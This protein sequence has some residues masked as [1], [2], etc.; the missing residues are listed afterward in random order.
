MNENEALGK[1]LD[2]I[3]T[4]LQERLRA[5]KRDEKAEARRMKIEAE[6][7]LQGNLQA[8][9]KQHAQ[10]MSTKAQQLL[11]EARDE[12]KARLWAFEQEAIH[13]I[14]TG[15]CTALSEQPF[16]S[17]QFDAWLNQ[18]KARLGNATELLLEVNAA[19]LSKANC[20]KISVQKRGMLGGAI[21]TDQQ[22]GQ[23]LDG[24]WECRLSDLMPEIW[25]RWKQDVGKDYQA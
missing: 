3:E 23:Q 24:S 1:L 18:A 22:S 19:W 25:Q 20:Q 15:I 4:R 5:I 21:L 16:R 8:R 13:E 17:D 11:R 12:Q 9:R 14:E 7:Q 2:D 6:S 10:D